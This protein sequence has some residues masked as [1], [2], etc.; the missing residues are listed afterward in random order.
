MDSQLP[1]LNAVYPTDQFRSVG[2]YPSLEAQ[3]SGDRLDN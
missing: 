3:I 2:V 1:E